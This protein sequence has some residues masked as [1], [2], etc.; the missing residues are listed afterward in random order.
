MA[1]KKTYGFGIV[2]CGLIAPFHAQAIGDLKGGRLVAVASRSAAKARQVADAWPGCEVHTDYRQMLKR[3]DLDIINICT[4]SGLHKE[5]ALSAIK[6]GKHVVVEKPLEVTLPR[7]DAIIRAAD[8]AKV[9]C[10]VIFPSRFSDANMELKR[11]VDQKRF[12]RLTLGDTY[13]KWW[14]D[15]KYYDQGG[16]HGTMKL[17][18]GG[19]LMNQSIHQVDLLQWIMGPVAEV[20]AFTGSLAHKRIEVED[21]AVAALRFK[22]GALGTIEGTT[23]VWPGLL[24]KIEI[25]GDAGTVL[26]EQDDILRWE[27]AK[28]RPRDRV[29]RRQFAAKRSGGGGASDPGA[30]SHVGHARQ[31]AG[32]LAA[33]DAGRSPECDGREGRKAVEIILA[34][35]KSQRTGRTVK[36]TG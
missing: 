19:S 8:K 33:L 20:T 4:P 6:A 5:F 35:Y 7:C 24:K 10:C 30:I 16:W 17:D 26:I 14:R 11:A 29:V 13:V 2:G 3:D 28:K 23:S 36:L 1:K 22:N 31:L 15:Q 27:F 12:G 18:G 32:F 9:K 25:H 21:T 34:I